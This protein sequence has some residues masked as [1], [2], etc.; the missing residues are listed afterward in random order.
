MKPVFARAFPEAVVVEA[1]DPPH[2]AT[3]SVHFH[4]PLGNI[5]RWLRPNLASF[6]VQK[7]FLKA[8]PARSRALRE[9]YGQGPLVG[10]AWRSKN[11]A[12]GGQKSIPLAAWKPVL[13]VP[14]VKWINLQYGDVAEELAKIRE[15][16]GIEIRNDPEI[17]QLADMDAL[18]AQV[19]A[20]DLVITTSQTVAHVAG[21]LGVPVWILLPRGEGLLWYWFLE[22][23][24][25]PFYPSARLFRQASRGGW[26]EI[27]ERVA[28]L[29]GRN[30]DKT[31][32]P[33][34]DR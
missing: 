31:D 23:E 13:T 15:S 24:K 12:I 34:D 14:G 5:G 9:R 17:D 33:D 21:A 7:S 18:L 6:P 1:S 19:A 11:A 2:P 20:L 16:F 22:G 25:S 30:G 10:I 8:D 27:L 28:A 32:D 29:L 26:S 3:Q 4:A